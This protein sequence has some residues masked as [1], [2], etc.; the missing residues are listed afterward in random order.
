VNL[1]DVVV[2][3][4]AIAAA[5]RGY[6]R[7]LLG[8]A[9]EFGGGFLGLVIGVA[10]GPRIASAFTN[11]AG[12]T[13]VLISLLVVFVALSIGQT[14]G[15]M[16]GHRFGTYAHSAQLGAWDSGLGAA[17]GIGVVLVAFWLVGALLVNGP[18]RSLA[19]AL[20]QSTILSEVNEALPKPP[21]VLAYISQYL[22]TSGFPRVFAG[23]PPSI[24][25]PVD[26]PSG[27]LAQRA[28]RAADQSTVRVVVPAC[29]GT[30][31]GTG[32]V[33]ADSTVVTNAH[34]V[35]GGDGVTVQDS[36]GDHAGVVVVFNPRA[37]V[38]VI[39]A[40]GLAGPP[41]ALHTRDED[42]GARGATLGYPGSAA[43]RLV[44]HRAA[45]QAR[46]EARGYDIY[47]RREVVREVYEIRSPVRQG[48]SGGP[49]VLP[50]GQVAGVVFAAS[51]TD[52]DTGYAL[53][54][55]EVSDEVERG[56]RNTSEVGTGACTH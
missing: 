20:E 51:T 13:A 40:E 25:P 29:G 42:R 33:A 47:G 18:S 43:G 1:V 9:F 46:Y 27:P 7:G 50:D 52:F 28:A 19:R 32:W 31:L 5:F 24:G 11:R 41:L 16:L 22:N 8:Q 14:L 26:L 54:G 36:A 39:R 23:V 35:A 21:N 30:Q 34:V 37:D 12:L 38:A 55:G 44:R 49:F 53:T 10:L 4:L 6:R 45:V 15:F 3:V 2:I 48:D 56:S 17:F